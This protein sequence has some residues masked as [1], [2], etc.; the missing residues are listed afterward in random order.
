MFPMYGRLEDCE[1][2]PRDRKIYQAAR[3]TSALAS[4]LQRIL[5]KVTLPYEAYSCFCFRRAEVTLD[6]RTGKRWPLRVIPT[7]F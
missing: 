2:Q 6:L 7:R 3:D 5:R 1:P 4:F